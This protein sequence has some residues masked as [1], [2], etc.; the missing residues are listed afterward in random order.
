MFKLIRGHITLLLCCSLLRCRTTVGYGR[1]KP[2]AGVHVGQKRKKP[3]LTADQICDVAKGEMYLY[4][5]V[6]TYG[7]TSGLHPARRAL[8]TTSANAFKRQ[9]GSVHTKSSMT[10][11]ISSRH[12]V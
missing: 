9:A 5:F 1:E 11:I 12:L 3:R 7:D 2:S 8:E 6:T 10:F 4:G